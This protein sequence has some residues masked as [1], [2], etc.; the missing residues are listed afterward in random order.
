MIKLW[1]GTML[2]LVGDV[3]ATAHSPWRIAVLWATASTVLAGIYVGIQ[4]ERMRQ[5]R[6]TLAEAL[7]EQDEMFR[8][9]GWS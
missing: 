5:A 7:Q 9:G 4:A 1:V 8:D 2:I 6:L 3:I